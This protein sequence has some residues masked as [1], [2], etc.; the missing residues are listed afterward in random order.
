MPTSFPFALVP[1]SPVARTRRHLCAAALSLLLGAGVAGAQPDGQEDIRTLVDRLADPRPDVWQAAARALAGRKEAAIPALF[2]AIEA[3]ER[4]AVQARAARLLGDLGARTAADRFTTWLADE[5]TDPTLRREAARALG[6]LRIPSARDLLVAYLDKDLA[7]A[8]EALG[9]IGEDVVLPDLVAQLLKPM[10]GREQAVVGLA[11]GRLGSRAGIDLLF[12]LAFRPTGDEVIEAIRGLKECLDPEL[13]VPAEVVPERTA[14][15]RLQM[16]WNRESTTMPLRVGPPAPSTALRARLESLAGEVGTHRTEAERR[17]YHVIM[18]SLRRPAAEA[19]IE[20][21][22]RDLAS[23]AQ[24]EVT[25]ILVDMGPYAVAP[26]VNALTGEKPLVLTNALRVLAR[27]PVQGRR[28]P[29]LQPLLVKTETPALV[30]LYSGK[31]DDPSTRVELM[32]L[33][34]WVGGQASAAPL[35][36][37]LTDKGGEAPSVRLAAARSLGLIGMIEGRKP[38]W[39]VVE[40]P[41]ESLVLRAEAAFSSAL[42][43]EPRAIGRLIELLDESD[44]PIPFL[45]R[46][47][48]WTYFGY[49]VDG[50]GAV[51]RWKRWWKKYAAVIRVNSTRVKLELLW[52]RENEVFRRDLRR[53]WLAGLGSRARWIDR[54]DQEARCLP[55]AVRMMPTLEEVVRRGEDGWIRFHAVQMMAI[56]GERAAVPALV[57]ALRDPVPLVRSTAAEGLG[58]IGRDFGYE[59]Y[60]LGLKAALL[61]R[62]E[63]ADPYVRIQT[64]LALAR[65]R[66]ADGV[67]ALI[68][69]LDHPDPGAQDFAWMT[70]RKVTDG[71][72]FDFN[73]QASLAAR[74][75]AVAALRAWWEKEGK[76]FRPYLPAKR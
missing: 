10:D 11:L 31:A 19:L 33:L 4:L 48:S 36:A 32:D 42:L 8:A 7:V 37:V 23:E 34:G 53:D 71:R 58:L 45:R 39:T 22:A 9:R 28:F 12:N 68:D 40:D 69:A 52:E 35:S 30:V 2:E 47:S 65:L 3:D 38:L 76:T 55:I 20:T 70:L 21:F 18:V 43:G 66:Y 67:P 46:L 49:E 63:D 26:L 60:S 15:Y 59:D 56:L 75:K 5:K 27:L 44:R 73:P 41:R 17:R 24:D 61:P 6:R 25:R 29:G 13:V 16:R 72:D 51:A 54:V 64:A 50:A 14:V 57:R 62:L 74:R 1:A